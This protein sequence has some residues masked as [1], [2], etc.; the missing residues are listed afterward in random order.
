M[1]YLECDAEEW[2][3]KHKIEIMEC[4]CPT[5]GLS[6]RTTIA[7]VTKKSY[8]LVTPSHDCKQPHEGYTFVPKSQYR[9]TVNL[10]SAI[11]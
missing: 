1:I 4:T 3:E 7:V 8:G 9:G 10:V 5:C 2:A 11:F 6:Q